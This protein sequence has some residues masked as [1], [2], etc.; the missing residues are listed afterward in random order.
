MAS[1]LA[2]AVGLIAARPTP[3]QLRAEQLVI[4]VFA[5]MQ[6]RD[7]LLRQRDRQNVARC[8][9]GYRLAVA[10]DMRFTAAGI[11]QRR[12]DLTRARQYE[13]PI[14]ERMWANRHHDEGVDVRLD[15]RAAAR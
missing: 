1:R 14:A 11:V 5:R 13:R 15:D 3:V 8:H 2:A 12:T 6:Q 4:V 10:D 7:G 9:P